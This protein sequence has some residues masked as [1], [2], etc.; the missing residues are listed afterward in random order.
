MRL[1][2]F[3]ARCI[4]LACNNAIAD[5]R[6]PPCGARLGRGSAFK[7]TATRILPGMAPENAQRASRSHAESSPAVDPYAAD[8]W[9][10]VPAQRHLMPSGSLLLL[11]TPWRKL[12]F[13]LARCRTSHFI[14]GVR[15]ESTNAAQSVPVRRVCHRQAVFQVCASVVCACLCAF[16]CLFVLSPVSHGSA[17]TPSPNDLLNAKHVPGPSCANPLSALTS[18]QLNK[19]KSNRSQLELRSATAAAVL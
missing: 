1:R 18:K 10:L 19:C 8:V 5:N 17:T 9:L 7:A 14:R 15:K 3:I 16:Y 13:A 12:R 11:S 6:S 2:E 4:H